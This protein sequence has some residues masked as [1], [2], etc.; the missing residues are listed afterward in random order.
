M[1]SEPT[2]YSLKSLLRIGLYI[3]LGVSAVLLGAITLR[4]ESSAVYID[5]ALITA[6]SPQLS[7]IITANSSETAARAVNATGGTITSDL[8][9]VDAVGATISADELQNLAAMPGVRAITENQQVETA[10]DHVYAWEGWVTDRRNFTQSHYLSGDMWFRPMT[11]PDG[12][13]FTLIE[14]GD[15]YIL[16]MDGTVRAS[17]SLNGKPFRSAPV[18]GP[19]GRIY[20]VGK[21][22]AYSINPD[23]SI[24]WQV[25]AGVDKFE[26]GIATNSNT[27]FI[28]NASQKVIALDINNG[29]LSWV[30]SLPSGDKITAPP[31]TSADGTVYTISELGYLKAINP[32]NGTVLWTYAA[33]QGA[34]Y[35]L[36]PIVDSSGTIYIT[37]EAG[38]IYAI[39]S[40]GSLKYSYT[41]SGSLLA[42]PILDADNTLYVG[43]DTGKL[44]AINS[45]GTVRFQWQAAGGLKFQASPALSLDETQVRNYL[46]WTPQ[47][48]RLTGVMQPL[49]GLLPALSLHRMTIFMSVINLVL[50]RL[51]PPK[52]WVFIGTMALVN[53]L[54]VRRCRMMAACSSTTTKRILW[55]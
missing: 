35:Y 12:G 10:D 1:K 55:C 28:A 20:I 54:L 37:G 13:V 26:G 14:K 52:G 36:K 11:L 29:Q 39:N 38:K 9:L 45:D 43:T 25:I 3:C 15:G 8:W 33:P 19:D 32:V 40:N 31:A 27:V 34:T 42:S 53:S 21:T 2:R 48:A 23:G 49:V 46:P 22:Q 44:I 50:T 18:L 51:S 24:Y 17:F 6:V 47:T 7:V 16:N 30:T 4:P 41:T 5:P